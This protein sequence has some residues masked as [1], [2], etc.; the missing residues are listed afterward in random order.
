MEWPS[1]LILV[2]A[3]VLGLMLAERIERRRDDL[4]VLRLLAELLGLY[5]LIGVAL[6][7]VWL[8]FGGEDDLPSPLAFALIGIPAMS[9]WAEAPTI[10][11]LAL[12]LRW[13]V[14]G[15]VL[16]LP[17]LGVRVG[18]ALLRPA[19]WGAALALLPWVAALGAAS[20]LLALLW[21]WL[22]RVWVLPARGQGGK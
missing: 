19:S 1:L 20:G 15:A 2:P 4:P 6:A 11:A 10:R 18:T 14:L 21:T 13:T 3:V 7:A 12:P 16:L 8:I 17:L 5:L 9:R 22:E